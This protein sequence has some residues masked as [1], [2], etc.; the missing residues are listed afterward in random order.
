MFRV[1]DSGPGLSEQ[2][3]AAAFRRG[4]STKAAPGTQSR[5]LGLALVAQAVRRHGGTIVCNSPRP[6]APGSTGT[7]AARGAVFT[8]RIPLPNATQEDER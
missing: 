4:W 1:G 5:G 6:D 3:V 7:S 2:D 8:C